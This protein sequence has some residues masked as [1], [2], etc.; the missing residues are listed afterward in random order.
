[1][2][3]IRTPSACSCGT[4]RDSATASSSI[5]PDT[6]SGGRFQFSE[7]NANTVST[8]TPR[9]P[10]WRTQARNASTPLLWPATRGR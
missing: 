5:R 10:Q 3:W 9:S 7:E 1:M 6:S 8:R 2:K 4:S